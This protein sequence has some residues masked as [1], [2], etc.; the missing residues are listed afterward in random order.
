MGTLGFEPRSEADFKESFFHRI[1]AQL[2][3]NWRL[4]FCQIILRPRKTLR[5]KEGLLIFLHF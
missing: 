5:D 3:S 2:S 4:L 1:N